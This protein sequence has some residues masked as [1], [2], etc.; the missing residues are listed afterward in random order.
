MNANIDSQFARIVFVPSASGNKKEVLISTMTNLN[1][2]GDMNRVLFCN[3][4]FSY[5]KANQYAQEIFYRITP[6]DIDLQ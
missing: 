5:K 2:P 1:I 4:M 6:I 3:G